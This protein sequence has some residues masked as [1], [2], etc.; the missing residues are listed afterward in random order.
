[1][2][3]YTSIYRYLLLPEKLINQARLILGRRYPPPLTT[4]T[5]RPII[6][7]RGGKEAKI[8]C[9]SDHWNRTNNESNDRR[10]SMDGRRNFLDLILVAT[11]AWNGKYRVPFVLGIIYREE[12][13]WFRLFVRI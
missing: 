3:R 1:M 8:V 6:F 2:S 5:D 11:F 13:R 10:I 7:E 4:A 12:G 9:N